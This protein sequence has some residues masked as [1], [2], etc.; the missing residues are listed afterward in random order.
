MLRR[1]RGGEGDTI[2]THSHLLL[3]LRLVKQMHCGN[4]HEPTTTNHHQT[5]T[6]KQQQV[7]HNSRAIFSLS[8]S[9]IR[10]FYRY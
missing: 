2:H 4:D 6:T 7:Q 10:P 3:L 9:F 5:N 1:R 8:L